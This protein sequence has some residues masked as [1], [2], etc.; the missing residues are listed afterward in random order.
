MEYRDDLRVLLLDGLPPG[1]RL[2]TLQT[3]DSATAAKLARLRRLGDDESDAM[4][5]DEMTTL[6]G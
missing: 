2:M 4:D 1:E 3:I 5:S 6:S